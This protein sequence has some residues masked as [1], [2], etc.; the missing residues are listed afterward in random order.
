[1]CALLLTWPSSSQMLD[2]VFFLGFSVPQAF[3]VDSLQGFLLGSF[4]VLLDMVGLVVG[5]YHHISGLSEVFAAHGK[6]LA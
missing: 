5:D 4:S 2:T 3:L 6:V 1:M